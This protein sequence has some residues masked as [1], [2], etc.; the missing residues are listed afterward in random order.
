MCK[1]EFQKYNNIPIAVLA[2]TELVFAEVVGGIFGVSIDIALAGCW[3][4]IISSNDFAGFSNKLHDAFCERNSGA[5]RLNSFE[6]APK[7]PNP[8]VVNEL[9]KDPNDCF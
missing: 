4:Y 5:I 1:T 8:L 3:L 6:L 2:S 9:A 7:P